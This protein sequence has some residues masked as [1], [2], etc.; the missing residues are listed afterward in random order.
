MIQLSTEQIYRLADYL[1]GTC[2]SLDGA[3]DALFG[4]DSAMELHAES[5]E[6]LENEVFLCSECGW[7]AETS[8]TEDR[9]GD[10]VCQDCFGG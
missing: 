9:D 5:L 7:W 10:V 3:L 6:L 1:M 4:I 2:N 8:E